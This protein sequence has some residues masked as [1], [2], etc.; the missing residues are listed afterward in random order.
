MSCVSVNLKK[1]EILIRID[2]NSE[3]EDVLTDLKLKLI[4]LKKLYQDAKTPIRVKGR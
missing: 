1:D 2:D 4:D 3:H